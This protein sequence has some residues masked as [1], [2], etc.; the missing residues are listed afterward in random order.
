M[1]A[2]DVLFSF[3]GRIPRRTFWLWY[4]G[5]SIAFSLICGILI[6]VASLTIKP[7][8]GK[9]SASA[10]PSASSS[11]LPGP[12]SAV[13]APSSSTDSS[14]T[15]VEFDPSQQELPA[16]FLAVLGVCG[17]LAIPMFWIVLALLAKRWH[18]RGKPAV[19]ILI[20]LIP[21][22]GAVWTLIECGCLR[23]TVGPNEFGAD[24]T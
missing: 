4:L 1:A 19:W 9:E 8:T 23:G 12:D 2:K 3:N 7:P 6:G 16:A 20:Y 11:A 13:P 5:S 10:T 15:P 17:L 24:P 14:S 22:V 18:D 21:F